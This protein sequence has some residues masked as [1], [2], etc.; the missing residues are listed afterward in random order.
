M[1]IKTQVMLIGCHRF[2][3][4]LCFLLKTTQVLISAI[5]VA[6]C[7]T[8]RTMTATKVVELSG[9]GKSGSLSLPGMH[10]IGAIGNCVDSVLFLER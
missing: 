6:T 2:Y 3:F 9:H 8:T 10:S 7:R 4:C 5:I 1:G